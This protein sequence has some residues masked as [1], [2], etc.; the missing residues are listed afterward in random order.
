M[1]PNEVGARKILSRVGWSLF[2]MAAATIVSQGVIFAITNYYF[3]EVLYSSW[4]GFSVTAVTVVGIGLPVFYMIIKKVPDSE[5]GEPQRLS[6]I[7]FIGFYF[8]CAA[9]MYLSNGFGQIINY[10]ISLIK[11][12]EVI[13]PIEEGIT[14]SNLTLNLLYVS[15]IGPIVEELIFR[16]LLLSKLRRFG[17]LPAILLTG[18]AFGLFH[19]N[20]YQFF[21]ATVLGIFF[22]YITIRTNTVRYSILLHIM[23]NFMG[24][25]VAMFVANSENAGYIGLLGLWVIFSITMGIILFFRNVKGVVLEKAEFPEEKKSVF[26]FNAGTIMFLLVC[27]I[28]TVDLIMR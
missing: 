15:V 13:N 18:F 14:N 23:I 21:Y 28:M 5:Q 20:L 9:F 6:V 19:M 1:E 10:I 12:G 11:G 17:D 7:Q 22:A 16:K 27:I 8:V 26:L 2:W 25:V 24:S 3:E 4:Y